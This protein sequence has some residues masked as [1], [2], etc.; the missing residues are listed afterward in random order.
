MLRVRAA[1]SGR[2][3]FVYDEAGRKAWIVDVNE[4]VV[5][6]RDLAG[7]TK[8]MDRPALVVYFDETPEKP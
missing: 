8:G 6:E 2:T 3:W 5:S 1:P 7:V 4:N